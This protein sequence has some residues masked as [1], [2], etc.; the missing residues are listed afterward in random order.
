ML[1]ENEYNIYGIIMLFILH[2]IILLLCFQCRCINL[3]AVF[4]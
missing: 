3:M 2:A 1:A 4:Y